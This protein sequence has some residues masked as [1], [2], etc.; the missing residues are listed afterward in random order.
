MSE[1]LYGPRADLY[2]AIYAWKDYAAE[3][4]RLHVLLA[5]EG[6][7]DGARV[8]EA[9]CGTGKHLAELRRWYTVAGVDLSAEMLAIARAR[10]PD[11]PLTQADMRDPIFGPRADA[12]LCLFSSIAYL[13]DRDALTAALRAF[14]ASVR[15]GGTVIIEPWIAPEDFSPGRVGMVRT[16]TDALKVCRMHSATLEGDRS[17]LDFAWLVGRPGKPIEHF[18]ERHALWLCPRPVFADALD[19]AGFDARFEPDGLM[20]QRG[21]WIARRR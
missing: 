11:V 3:A 18:T 9:A 16:D 6:V 8:V 17:V 13:H 10:L 5:E 7:A 2:D 21:L 19:T 14:A 4:E 12:L 1:L 15:P 20:K